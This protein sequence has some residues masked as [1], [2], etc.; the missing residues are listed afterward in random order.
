MSYKVSSLSSFLNNIFLSHS[1]F[2]FFKKNNKSA[3]QNELMKKG[4]LAF[5][6][7][8][9]VYRRDEIDATHYP[10]FHQMEGVRVF[11]E[12]ELGT[13]DEKQKTQLVLE[14]LKISLEGMVKRINL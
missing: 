12:E 3:H 8:G 5:L 13:K 9:D 11:T 14:D 7:T 6:A 4:S 1:L 2:L 10:I